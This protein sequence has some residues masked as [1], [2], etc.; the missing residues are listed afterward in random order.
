MAWGVILLWILLGGA[1][2]F[3][4]RRRLKAFLQRIP[5]DWKISFF[6]LATLLAMCEEAITTLMTNCAPIFGVKLGEAYITASANY[7]DVILCHS[8]ITF[9]PAFAA[10][11]WLYSRYDFTPF[12]VFVSFGIYGT[13]G[14]ALHGGFQHLAEFGFW[15]FVYGL[16]IYLP[17]YL[18]ADYRGKRR[19]SWP[20]YLMGTLGLFVCTLPWIAFLKLTLLRN[21]P[22]THFP[23]MQFH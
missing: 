23:P 15:L 20:Q 8:V 9:L 17:A 11:V 10:W 13:L 2:M 1:L 16:M 7:L 4:S 19:V 21:Q 5:L 22:D 18:F 14:E 6:L 3:L 12:E